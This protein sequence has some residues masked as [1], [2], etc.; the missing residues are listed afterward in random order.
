[1]PDVFDP[2]T[3]PLRAIRD[4]IAI[5]EDRIDPLDTEANAIL[6]R[7]RAGFETLRGFFGDGRPN[8]AVAYGPLLEPAL[9][10]RPD[11]TVHEIGA[12]TETHPLEEGQ[13]SKFLASGDQR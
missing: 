7:A 5:N 4:L 2:S 9:V 3:E 13:I 1:M 10:E 12:P 6:D 11:V 8:E